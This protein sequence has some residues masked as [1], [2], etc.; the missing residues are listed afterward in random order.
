MDGGDTPA[1]VG[2]YAYALI[3]NGRVDEARAFIEAVDA[4][5]FVR[6]GIMIR[7]PE[8]WDEP[9]DFSRDQQTPMVIAYEALG[10][11]N[12]HKIYQRHHERG[13]RYQNLDWASWEHR[14]YYSPKNRDWRGDALMLINSLI[15]LIDS[16]ARPDGSVGP[17]QNHIMALLQA[18]SNLPTPLSIMACWV[19][20]WR[21]KGIQWAVNH[22]Y[23][24]DNPLIA[25]EFEAPI[26]RWLVRK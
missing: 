12:L 6:P 2:R 11:P 13:W 24:T 3:L 1:D 20:S 17:D 25:R 26:K 19:Y 15:R 9:C 7:H 8:T 23:R 4:N 21:R 18:Q 16:Y 14:N 22:Y 5:C 10:H